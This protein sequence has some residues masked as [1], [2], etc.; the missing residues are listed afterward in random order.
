MLR[1]DPGEGRIRTT[2]QFRVWEGGGSSERMRSSVDLWGDDLS[3]TFLLEHYSAVLTNQDWEI[4]NTS[5]DDT[6]AWLNTTYTDENGTQWLGQM[7]ITAH[8]LNETQFSA[9]FDLSRIDE[10]D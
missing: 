7:V 5:E 8:P 4:I 9:S 2:R 3:T 1:L 6:M 10:E